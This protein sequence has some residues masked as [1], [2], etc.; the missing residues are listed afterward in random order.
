M[1][2]SVSFNRAIQQLYPNIHTAKN[3]GRSKLVVYR[4]IGGIT[5]VGHGKPPPAKNTFGRVERVPTVTNVRLEPGMQIHWLQAVKKPHYQTCGNANA[6]AQCDTKM[7]KITTHSFALRIH[8]D[9]GQ[10]EY[11][12]SGSLAYRAPDP[13]ADSVYL[14]VTEL[15]PIDDISRKIPKPVRFTI[16]TGEQIQ[17]DRI[18]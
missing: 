18:G 17:Q 5:P 10:R 7:G 8:L 14:I 2:T 13:V 4:N 16:A 12:G 15:H 9:S 1:E 11:T 6:T 3:S